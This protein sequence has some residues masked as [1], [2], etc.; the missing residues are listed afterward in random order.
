MFFLGTRPFLG[1]AMEAHLKVQE[2]SGG[3]V[4]AAAEDTLGFRHGFMAAVDA[5]SLI[6]LFLSR[7]P[8]RRRYELDLLKELHDKR[9][10]RKSIVVCDGREGLGQAPSDGPPRREVIDYGPAPGVTDEVRA[11]LLA[12]TGQLFGLFF[13]LRAGLHPDNPSP[14]GIIARIVQGVRIYPYGAR[15]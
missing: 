13:S 9:L 6:A 15:E 14:S 1:G 3:T 4:V 11:P 8:H 7:D 10:G 2:L 12:V 5:D